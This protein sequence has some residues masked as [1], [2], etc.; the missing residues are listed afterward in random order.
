MSPIAEQTKAVAENAGAGVLTKIDAFITA[1]RSASADGLTWAEFGELLVALLKLSV[2]LYDDVRQLSGA[3]KKAAVL[4]AVG[5]LFDAVADKAVPV[6]VYPI[7]IFARP[8]VRSLVL[9]LAAGAIEQL[10]PLVRVA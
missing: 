2:S 7:W 3:E 1:A 10:L 8:A 5:R 6:A 9:A 4:D